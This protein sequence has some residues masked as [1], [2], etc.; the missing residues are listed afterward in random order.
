M[1]IREIAL[2]KYLSIQT[3]HKHIDHTD[4]L[5]GAVYLILEAVE[6]Q[7]FLGS[8]NEVD[9]GQYYKSELWL[10][11]MN[12][13]NIYDPEQDLSI[14]KALRNLEVM[15]KANLSHFDGLLDTSAY[16]DFLEL[17]SKRV[18][19][20]DRSSIKDEDMLW[21]NALEFCRQLT[22]N[23][24]D[25]ILN[26]YEHLYDESKW[27]IKQRKVAN[28]TPNFKTNWESAHRNLKAV[29]EFQADSGESRAEEIRS[30]ILLKTYL[31]PAVLRL[32]AARPQLFNFDHGCKPTAE[33]LAKVIDSAVEIQE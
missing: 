24:E 18:A 21:T 1:Q 13:H 2:P 20:Y 6:R 27:S 9:A 29:L 11:V 23:A 8:L 5:C 12:I 7:S 19:H 22:Q 33:Y 30:M 31:E 3:N 16:Q 10:Q 4:I 14:H 17:R 15:T 26:A 25:V 32:I 28:K